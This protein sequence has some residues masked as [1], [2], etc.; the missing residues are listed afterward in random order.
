[1]RSADADVAQNPSV[2]ITPI[3]NMLRDYERLQAWRH[4]RRWARKNLRRMNAANAVI[5]SHTKS[6]RT[7]LRVMISHVYHLEYGIPADEVIN[8]DN[9]HRFNHA[10]PKLFFFRDTVLPTFRWRDAGVAVPADK[11]CLF[12]VRDPRDVAVSFHFHVRNRATPRELDRKGIPEQARSLSIQD[13]V[14][15][16]TLGVPR[17]V[18]HYNRWRQDMERIAQTLMIRYEDMQAN[19]GAELARAMEFI[20]RGFDT[21]KLERA[22][23]FASFESMAKKEANGYFSSAKLI[24]A[25]R[26]DANS[27][28]VRRGK[29]RGYRD[30]FSDEQNAALDK[31]V[32]EQLD[33]YYGYN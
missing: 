23:E 7:W 6:G 15:E 31:I 24:P 11:R 19:A 8:F 21:G 14:M 1:M 32:R 25:D 30:Y 27:F 20:D 13:F 5:I 17:V 22:V 9:F 29:V 18:E 12:F 16:P 3:G 2:Y 10:I 4:R 33:P 28:K 26:E